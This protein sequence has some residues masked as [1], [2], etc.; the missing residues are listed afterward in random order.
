MSYGLVGWGEGLC[1]HASIP[2][3]PLIKKKNY[4]SVFGLLMRA[5]LYYN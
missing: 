3:S 5:G 4:P 1:K 2:P